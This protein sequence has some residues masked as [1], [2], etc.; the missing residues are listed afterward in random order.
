[1]LGVHQPVPACPICVVPLWQE[2]ALTKYCAWSMRQRM[3]FGE[4]HAHQHNPGRSSGDC[5]YFFS[6]RSADLESSILPFIYQ[7]QDRRLQA[8]AFHRR[9]ERC[10]ASATKAK[11]PVEHWANAY[12]QYLLLAGVPCCCR[13]FIGIAPLF[14]SH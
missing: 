12:L 8:G 1:M 4:S 10:A 13:N 2:Q 5:T 9:N 3:S 7:E 6:R 14:P 11:R